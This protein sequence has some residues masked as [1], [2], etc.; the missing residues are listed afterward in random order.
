MIERPQMVYY[1]RTGRDVPRG[2]ALASQN[3][4]EQN[5]P[6]DAVL[7]LEAALQLNQPTAG[8][9]VLRWMSATGYTDPVLAPLAAKLQAQLKGAR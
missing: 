6:A 3:W 8:E 9:P 1:I 2:L 4:R 5:E 7:L